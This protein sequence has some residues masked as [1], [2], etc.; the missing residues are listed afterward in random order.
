[1][2][3]PKM[4][5]FDYGQTLIN[6]LEFDGIKGTAEVMKYAIINKYNRTA[7][8]LQKAAESMNKE[9]GR[10]DPARSHMFQIEI[11]FG[12][13]TA[14][15][16]ESQGIKLSLPYDQTETLFWD[17]ASPGE[18]TEGIKEFL[19]F[20][21]EQG[22]RTGVIS[23]ITYSGR[24]LENRINTFLPDHDFEFILATS[25]YMYRKP[26]RRI[27]ELALEKVGLQAEEV[28]YI[29]DQYEC[30][31]VGSRNAG[32]FPVWYVGALRKAAEE[33]KDV[34]TIRNWNELMEV[35]GGGRS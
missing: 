32:M 26:N 17:A 24:A 2:K 11:P 4:I 31:V 15:L 27:F 16:Y 25:E 10:F 19:L 30:D 13:F 14:Y 29:G 28:W 35:L 12:M 33:R 9:M 20:L 8:E 5:V 18:V 23:N 21:K 34:L 3:K 6:E 7:E 1:M 22:I